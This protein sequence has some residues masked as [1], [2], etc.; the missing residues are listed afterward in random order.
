MRQSHQKFNHLGLQ[1]C[2]IVLGLA[3]YN[4][5]VIDKRKGWISIGEQ[6]RRN[7]V[8]NIRLSKMGVQDCH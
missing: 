7:E 2:K 5:C 1:P 3:K 6:S 8:L 4:A